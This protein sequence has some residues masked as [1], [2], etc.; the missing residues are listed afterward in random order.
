MQPSIQHTVDPPRAMQ[1]TPG[2]VSSLRWRMALLL[3]AFFLLVAVSAAATAWIVETQAQDALVI[4]LAGRQRMLVQQMTA[5]A[6]RIERGET[7]DQAQALQTAIDTFDQTLGALRSGGP[8]PYLPGQT[9]DVPAASTPELRAALE[10]QAREWETLRAHL[11]VVARQT[12]GTPGFAAAA[13]AVQTLSPSLVQRADEVV[14]LYEAASERKV[15]RLRGVQAA[16]FASALCLL[17]I[18]SLTIYRGVVR[19]LRVL[20]AASSRIAAGDFETRITSQGPD[21][22]RALAASMDDMRAQLKRSREEL[23]RWAGE[24][25]TQVARRT[26]ELAAL[27]EVSREISSHLEIDQVLRSVTG[28][29]RGLL[30]SDVAMLCFLDEAGQALDLK[31]FSGAP[32]AALRAQTSAL[33][34]LAQRVLGASAA[35][36]C[37]AG[38]CPG[39]CRIVDP[40]FR[41]SHLAMP[42]RAGERVIGA[43]C[44]GRA[45]RGG[46]S[47]EETRLLSELGRS[48]TIALE[49][50]RLYEQAERISA[51]EERQRIAA[52]MHDGLAQTLSTLGMRI[53]GLA[54][55]VDAGHGEETLDELARLQQAVDAAGRDVRRS[56]AALQESQGTPRTLADRL[57]ELVDG[58]AGQEGAPVELVASPGGESPVTPDQAEQVIRV[59][60]EAIHNARRHAQAARITAR[61]ER[62]GDSLRLTVE[63]DGRGFD[64]AALPENAGHF[65]LS[66]MRARAAR[67]GGELGVDAA[68]GRGARISLTWPVHEET[69]G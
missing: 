40:A 69:T 44:V 48:A 43:L 25:E 6:L 53:E 37:A 10:S 3:G 64:P 66:I 50:A 4:N 29:A 61:L 16:F 35:L 13:Q 34:P 33:E 47:E 9:E 41:A 31:A 23:V 57:A 52:D 17:V 46:F 7:G 38:D 2:L 58:F 5:Q 60:G 21:E 12:P 67:I 56:I 42:L 59:A 49:N 45:Q 62:A 63:D 11:E 68:P 28:K 54:G 14:R 18:G 39:T 15:A 26:Q 30:E 36:P 32:E 19:P 22:I 8:A 24:L 55:L 20:G 27:Y 65:G 51:L 1:P